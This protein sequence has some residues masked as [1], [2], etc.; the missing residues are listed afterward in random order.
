V[1]TVFLP[2]LVQVIFTV[3]GAAAFV[4]LGAGAGAASFSWLNFTLIVGEENV[5]PLADRY[6][7]PLRSLITVVATLRSPSC[8]VIEISAWIGAF[9]NP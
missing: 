6:S 3:F 9:E 8:E 7:Q 1:T 4:A 2:D 5:N